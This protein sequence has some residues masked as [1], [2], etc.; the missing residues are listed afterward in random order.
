MVAF[1]QDMRGIWAARHKRE[2][3][4]AFRTLKAKWW[5][6]EERAVRCLEKNLTACP[7]YLRFPVEPHKAIRTTNLVER[8][9]REMRR[10]TRP[11]DV[12]A[13]VESAERIMM[14]IGQQLNE[15]W[16]PASRIRCVTAVPRRYHQVSSRL[17]GVNR[18]R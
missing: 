5:V 17:S 6:E 11:M 9:F 18:V 7:V 3:L 10:G 16:R 4:A 15:A 8:M 14:G 2:A 12:F 1:A 13:N